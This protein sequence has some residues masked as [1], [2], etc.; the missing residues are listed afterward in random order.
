M[1]F[2]GLQVKR[3]I[4][5]LWNENCHTYQNTQVALLFWWNSILLFEIKGEE[6]KSLALK[7]LFVCRCSRIGQKRKC[8]CARILS[9]GNLVKIPV[10]K[11]KHSRAWCINIDLRVTSVSPI[12]PCLES[13]LNVMNTHVSHSFSIFPFIFVVG[14]SW[15]NFKCNLFLNFSGFVNSSLGICRFVLKSGVRWNNPVH[16][17][18]FSFIWF[19]AN[20]NSFFFFWNYSVLFQASKHIHHTLWFLTVWSLHKNTNKVLLQFWKQLLVIVFPWK[21]QIV[22]KRSVH[23]LTT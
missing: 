8:G 22:Q 1:F 5:I 6:Q 3:G 2:M 12:T 4:C 13:N 15:F 18:L 16:D 23:H 11:K 17:S 21:L 10:E 7:F 9:I 20:F 19:S 14:N